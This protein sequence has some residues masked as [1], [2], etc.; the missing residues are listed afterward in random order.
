[1]ATSTN[2]TPAPASTYAAILCVAA[3][4][5]IAVVAAA[6]SNAALAA[7]AL[8]A[9]LVPLMATARFTGDYRP[10]WALAWTIG[11][12]GALGSLVTEWRSPWGAMATVAVVALFVLPPASTARSRR[13]GERRR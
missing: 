8:P 5:L 11:G 10:L 7:Q 3:T 6:Q 2:D 1:M 9:T 13:A 12:V 4:L